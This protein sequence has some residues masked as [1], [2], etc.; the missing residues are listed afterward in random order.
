MEKI[1]EILK[2]YAKAFIFLLIVTILMLAGT[3]AVMSFGD[4]MVTE[5]GE[6]MK[7]RGEN[8]IK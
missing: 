3:M 2:R 4:K 1:K 8:L 6:Q 7:P 5:I